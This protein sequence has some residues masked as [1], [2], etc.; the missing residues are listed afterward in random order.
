MVKD[1]FG[2]KITNATVPEFSEK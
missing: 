1:I 2:G